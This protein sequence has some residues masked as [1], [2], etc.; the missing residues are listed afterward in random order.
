MKILPIKPSNIAFQGIKQVKDKF[1]MPEYEF[2]YPFDDSVYDC[3]LEIYNVEKDKRGDYRITH[4]IDN[5][6][7]EDGR[8][9]LQSGKNR[10]DLAYSYFIDKDTP[11]AYHYK[12]V[13]KNNPS[14]VY[15]RVDSG[16]VIDNRQGMHDQ[17]E[18]YNFVTRDGSKMPKGGSMK[19]VIPDNYDPSY[20]YNSKNEIEKVS[21]DRLASSV[22]NFANKIGGSLA[23][24]EQ[25]VKNG[26]FDG[27]SNIISL[28]IFTDD[29]L[30]AH[31][32]WNKNCMQIIP[33]YGNINNYASL[34]RAM[35]AKGINWVSDGAFVNEGLEGVHFANLLKWGE[36]S[37]YYYWFKASGLN[38]GPF[39][40]GVFGKN[41]KNVSH[42]IVNS[43]YKYEQNKEGKIKISRN[44]DYNPN[45]PTYVQIFDNRLASKEQRRDNKN[46]IKS[47]D[48]LNTSNPYEINTH[49]D[50]TINY[51]FEIDPEVYHK[52]VKDLIEYNKSHNHKIKLFGGEGTR[53][54]NKYENFELEDKIESNF[55]TWDANTDI[56]KLNYV[57]SP[58]FLEDNINLTPKEKLDFC[59][60]NMIAN[61]QVRDYVISSGK[62][63]T[64]K[65]KDILMLYTAQQFK[66]IADSADAM[67]KIVSK[68]GHVIPKSILDNIDKATVNNI[69]NGDYAS[70]TKLSDEKYEDQILQ[71][72]MNYPLDAIEFGDNIVG[73]LASPY[74]TKRANVPEEVG[75]S[76]YDVYKN[77]NPNLQ[78]KNERAYLRT[79]NMYCNEMFN[80]AKNILD[81]VQKSLLPLSKNGEATNYG[82]YVL[83][84][85]TQEIAKFAVIKALYPKAKASVNQNG[86]IYYDYNA[87]KEINLQDLCIFAASPED[88]ALSIVSKIRSGI[89]NISE[90][91]KKILK[92]AL[93]K[94]FDGTNEKSFML[95]DAIVD[96]TQSGLDWRI[97]AA[98]DI[99]DIDAL[100]NGK[101]DFSYTWQQVTDFWKDFNDNVLKIN[102][103]SYLV[104]EVTDENAL[105]GIGNGNSSRISEDDII[106][107]FLNE[108]GMTATANYNSFFTDTAMM[109]G[110]KFEF[111]NS[112]MDKIIDDTF[113]KQIN[114]KMVGSSDYLRKTNLDSLLYSYT[115]VGNHDKPRTLH[116]F[117]LDMQQFFADLT[118]YDNA[119]DGYE[120][121]SIQ[122]E[123]PAYPKSLIDEYRKRAY[124]VLNNKFLDDVSDFEVEQF[125]F[126]KVS[127]K[128]VS[129]AEL[130][131]HGFS[132]AMNIM[133]SDSKFANKKSEVY[134]AI[135]KSISDL[136][137]GIYLD[138][139]FNADAFAVKPF[140]INIDAIIEQAKQKYNLSLSDDETAKLK[141]ETFNIILEPAF[142]KLLGAMKVLNALPGKPTLYYGDDLGETGYEEKTKNIYIQNR[143][144]IHKNWFDEK[145]LVKRFYNHINDIMSLRS[146]PEL[147]ALNNGA[148]FELPYQKG[149][150]GEVISGIL[151][152]NTDGKMAITL[153]NTYGM[154]HKNQEL[155]SA[156]KVYIDCINLNQYYTDSNGKLIDK[157]GL[158]CGIKPGT[159]FRNAVNKDEKFVVYRH[160]DG[161]YHLH[162]E[163]GSPICIDDTTLILYSDPDEGKNKISF[164]G[165]IGYK[166]AAKLVANAYKNVSFI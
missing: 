113:H 9:K 134:E 152:Q 32:Y 41:I 96:L 126:S 48:I 130:M 91:D 159:I 64:Q 124:K 16:D 66:N 65:T 29:S 78:K 156:D 89:S 147:D 109:F 12:L 94:S 155:Y 7:S 10:V 107:K 123:N 138:D 141:N 128:A 54:V 53:F 108:T 18:I 38:N 137:N 68:A 102:P 101:S 85:M 127:S 69:M 111:D 153:F 142:T 67:Q 36:K 132:N 74:I 165:N 145:P 71:G 97:D 23:G 28:P 47:Y 79:Q 129:M 87:L 125:D 144:Y 118:L 110:K 19:L 75:L 49:D 76:R 24:I 20:R 43:P 131:M 116:C 95:A 6:D 166:P 160:D 120:I 81:D 154:H 86:E 22:K 119:K 140:N 105:Y 45:K 93:I 104:A 46:L 5:T 56:A 37:P 58:A 25:A 52:N 26:D 82:K 163:D 84:L 17:Y 100:R 60:Q 103:N 114:D 150:N 83:P 21:N 135:A 90:S 115:F 139:N 117:A 33:T 44:S 63:W 162:H 99:A 51:H 2:N 121:D 149:T 133:A 157:I 62:Y 3:Y 50:T 136:A 70:T 39:L 34:Q 31:G 146:R 148:P 1:G 106:K 72:L 88:E 4:L 77:G 161:G 57:F 35:Y 13:N 80:F 55:E 122:K 73:V 27:Y 14:E 8:F 30:S 98:K 164:T 15:F 143:G 151:R 42:K 158:K 112:L 11:F 61:N 92:E 59:E 40:L